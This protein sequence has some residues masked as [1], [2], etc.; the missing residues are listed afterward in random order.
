[1]LWLLTP[2]SLRAISWFHGDFN[3]ALLEDRSYLHAVTQALKQVALEHVFSHKEVEKLELQGYRIIN[4]L[5]E[6]YKP[7]LQLT[8]TSRALSICMKLKLH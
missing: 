7:L 5:L 4:G 3:H 8:S 2:S 6:C 1:M